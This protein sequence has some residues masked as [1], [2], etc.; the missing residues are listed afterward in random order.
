MLDESRHINQNA[1]VFMNLFFLLFQFKKCTK[2]WAY[3]Y[4]VQNFILWKFVCES[5]Y[6]R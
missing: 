2:L 5:A 6:F 3:S 1:I 4:K